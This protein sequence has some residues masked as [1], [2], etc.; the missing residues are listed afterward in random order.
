MQ[1]MNF[2][3]KPLSDRMCDSFP[4]EASFQATT[5]GFHHVTVESGTATDIIRWFAHF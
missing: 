3:E 4:G 2:T 1:E 5:N